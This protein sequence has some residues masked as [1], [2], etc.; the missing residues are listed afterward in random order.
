MFLSVCVCPD[1]DLVY[2]KCLER[3][4]GFEDSLDLFPSGYRSTIV[5]PEMSGA[6]R[7]LFLQFTC[8]IYYRKPCTF[9]VLRIFCC[10]DNALVLIDDIALCLTSSAVGKSQNTSKPC[11]LC[12]QAHS[13][14]LSLAIPLWVNE[15]FNIVYSH[16][17]PRYDDTDVPETK[18]HILGAVP[19]TT[20]DLYR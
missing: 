2:D 11:L 6:F 4:D 19:D 17:L 5:Q 14:Q 16:T 1:P 10:N 15:P 9:T 12:S 3:A 20:N 8:N 18:W 13:H 7:M